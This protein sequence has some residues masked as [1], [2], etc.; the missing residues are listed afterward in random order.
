MLFKSFFI[1]GLFILL[2]SCQQNSTP[3]DSALNTDSFDNVSSDQSEM[4]F[5]VSPSGDL[6]GMTDWQNIMNA[7]QNSKDANFPVTVKLAEGT[8]Y[9]C[10]PI[11]TQDFNGSIIGAGKERTIIKPA[12][13][14][15]DEGFSLVHSQLWDAGLAIL[16]L[17]EYPEQS[18]HLEGFTL[19]VDQLNVAQTWGSEFGMTSNDILEAISILL[20]KD[21]D[22]RIKDIKIKGIPR[23]VPGD[24]HFASPQL[25]IRLS[26][27]MD[28][29]TGQATFHGGN[30]ELLKCDFNTIGTATYLVEWLGNATVTVGGSESKGNHFQNCYMPVCA[31][32]NS[33]CD[34]TISHNTLLKTHWEG[35]YFANSVWEGPYGE[36]S[37]ATISNNFIELDG[38]AD[39][40]FIYDD[41]PVYFGYEPSIAVNVH[42]NQIALRDGTPLGIL[43]FGL[44]DA[45]MQRN[46]FSG[47]GQVL[48]Y[49][50]FLEDALLQGFM[51]HDMEDITFAPVYLGYGTQNCKLFGAGLQYKVYDWSDDPNT[52]EYD[53]LNY[54]WNVNMTYDD[55]PLTRKDAMLEKADQMNKPYLRESW[56]NVFSK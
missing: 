6:T 26:G 49:S 23:Y 14:P 33:G 2:I 16:M 38:Y 32:A 51:V 21:C 25:G 55:L 13:G 15:A 9:I 35:I 41:W 12:K 40:I 24:Y 27:E 17:F 29:E 50:Y 39:G 54:L 46:Q 47:S 22:T 44:N 11:A 19:E 48:F 56:E 20:N 28:W 8:F 3:F 31:W 5:Y 37:H 34:Y 1:F 30:H 10:S 4:I 43:F 45:K 7:L 52:P 18:I 36:L 42:D 53:G